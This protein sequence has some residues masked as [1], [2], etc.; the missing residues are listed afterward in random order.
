MF[1]LYKEASLTQLCRIY[2]FVHPA[3]GPYRE[4]RGL[5]RIEYLLLGHIFHDFLNGQSVEGVIE[6]V[7]ESNLVLKDGNNQAKIPI[8]SIKLAKLKLK[9]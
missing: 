5:R 7:E 8:D 3:Y 1:Y 2:Y 4:C 6:K 9:W